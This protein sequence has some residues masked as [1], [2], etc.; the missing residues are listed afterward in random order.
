M[1]E[2]PS[3]AVTAARAA[4]SSPSGDGA[5]VMAASAMASPGHGV[6]LTAVLDHVESLALDDA[7]LDLLRGRSL[8]EMAPRGD[9]P[10]YASEGIGDWSGA[11]HDAARLA[12]LAAPGFDM[13]FD[14]AGEGMHLAA[15]HPAFSA[16]ADVMIP[17]AM[18]DPVVDLGSLA[19][20]PDSFAPTVHD[21][22]VHV[23][24][25]ADDVARFD[26]EALDVRA[27]E[28]S[29]LAAINGGGLHVG[30]A[31]AWSDVKGGYVFDH[32]V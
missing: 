11:T 32:Y 10:L 31:W 26:L 7:P 18:V 8:V 2:I 21:A 15:D 17:A 22:P 20:E 12:G 23:D 30:E 1:N 27:P 24:V 13:V 5:G 16:A 14:G 19:G 9:A 28:L 29:W 6:D 3:S 4:L 25:A